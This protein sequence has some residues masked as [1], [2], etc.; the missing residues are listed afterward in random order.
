M[1]EALLMSTSSSPDDSTLPFPDGTPFKGV[2]PS[3]LFINGDALASLIG[4]S[5]GTPHNGNAG[6]L[7]F[8]EDEGLEL[9]I[10]KKTMRIMVSWEQINAAQQSN[11]RE[12]TINDEV[13]LVRFLNGVTNATTYAWQRYLLNVYNSNDR[14]GFPANTPVWGNY[15]D[16]MLGVETVYRGE[17]DG[18]NT[19]C[20]EVFSGGRITRG[21]SWS[22]SGV[23]QI[24]GQWYI[25]ANTPQPW[26]GWRPCLVKKSSL[27]LLPFRGEVAQADF[28]TFSTLLTESGLTEGTAINPS[29][30]WLHFVTS[31]NKEIYISK[32]AIRKNLTWEQLNVLGLIKGTKTLVIGGKTYK[33]RV[34][35]MYASDGGG[36][37]SAPGREW[38]EC[39]VNITNGIYAAYTTTQLGTGT[40]GTTNGELSIGQEPD[41][42]GGHVAGAYQGISDMWYIIPNTTNNGYGWR[43]VLELVP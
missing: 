20:A 37:H 8:I 11:S 12:V 33:L 26:Y 28:I 19:I 38:L 30:P 13:Y 29:E 2:V 42:R 16:A 5:A 6:W 15:T 41:G 27:P 21:S 32:K 18:A 4:L 23:K 3:A 36:N 24:L 22:T 17:H 10:A 40:G 25:I 39:M 7:H 35:Q 9:Y 43:P 14:S 31:D 34:M 1:Y